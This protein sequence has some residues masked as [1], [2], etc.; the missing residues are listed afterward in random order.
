[1]SKEAHAEQVDEDDEQDPPADYKPVK[2]TVPVP[3]L[4]GKFK[5]GDF[6]TETIGGSKET[7]EV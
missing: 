5:V 2:E 3:E 1:M 6:A 4:T 7:V